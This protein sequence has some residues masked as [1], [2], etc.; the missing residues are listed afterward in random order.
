M[1]VPMRRL[2][3]PET[4]VASSE[5]GIV[6]GGECAIGGTDGMG[7]GC[8]WG[9]YCEDFTHEMVCDA[10]ERVCFEHGVETNT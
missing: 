8:A 3:F 2:G 1:H 10:V 5:S 7:M 9:I 6:T 4:P